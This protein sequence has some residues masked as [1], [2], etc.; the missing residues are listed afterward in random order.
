[1][2][3]TAADDSERARAALEEGSDSAFTLLLETYQP[4]L[5][6]RAARRLRHYPAL[7]RH[8]DADDLVQQFLHDKL[9]PPPRRRVMLTPVAQGTRP[10][11][12]R[13]CAS[14]E[15]WL[16]SALRGKTLP[17]SERPVGG[18]EDEYDPEDHPAEV[19]PDIAERITAQL[20]AIHSLPA[21]VRGAIP[22][23]AV[24]LLNERVLLA[25]QVADSFAPEDG[26]TVGNQG[27]REIVEILAAWLPAERSTA[28]PPRGLE[29]A[30]VWEQLCKATEDRPQCAGPADLADV[31]GASK[32]TWLQWVCRG[33]VK[34]VRHLGPNAARQLFPWWP[35][36]AFEQAAAAAREGE[37]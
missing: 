27:L 30:A 7:A 33:R 34:L 19:W 18:G 12:P 11:W 8:G 16:C 20:D 9:V 10:L 21:P 17:F 22:Y 14:F 26:R 32:A 2:S 5:R 6:E 15:N 23:A 24:L 31:L 13:L 37:P 36:T 35:P 28:L 4:R 1:M 29:L 25:R 3:D